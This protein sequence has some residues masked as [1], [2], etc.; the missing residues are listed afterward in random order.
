M[1]RI[2]NQSINKYPQKVAVE[3]GE[4]S[5]TSNELIFHAQQIVMFLLQDS[6]LTSRDVIYQSMKNNLS[7]VRCHLNKFPYFFIH[8]SLGN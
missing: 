3:Y 2:P 5:L 8:C 6:N 7:K 1:N 4:Q